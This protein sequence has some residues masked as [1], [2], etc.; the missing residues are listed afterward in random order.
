MICKLKKKFQYSV[1]QLENKNVVHKRQKKNKNKNKG[2]GEVGKEQ[3][4]RLTSFNCNR[5]EGKTNHTFLSFLPV[6]KRV[7]YYISLNSQYLFLRR[8]SDFQHLQLFSSYNLF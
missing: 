8:E 3:N 1:Q 2:R 7:F 5:N 6:A 4:I